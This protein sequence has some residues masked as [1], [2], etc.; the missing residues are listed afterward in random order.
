V[1]IGANQISYYIVRT[2]DANFA[3]TERIIPVADDFH[4]SCYRRSDNLQTR[5][6][7]D[8]YVCVVNDEAETVHT[9]SPLGAV[10]WEFCDGSHNA[11]QIANEVA[12]LGQL[13]EQDDVRGQVTKLLKWFLEL[14]LI[15]SSK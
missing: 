11:E 3:N 12:N 9:L 15:A 4:T 8:G 10:A 5:L 14:G 7:P 13:C 1:S 2:R 6:L